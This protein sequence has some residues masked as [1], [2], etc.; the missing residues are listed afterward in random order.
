MAQQ[1]S[2]FILWFFVAGAVA[3]TA[4]YTFGAVVGDKITWR[5]NSPLQDVL[6]ILTW[7]LWL[8][9]IFLFDAEHLSQ[10]IPALIISG[11]FNGGWYALIGLL[12]WK[13]RERV[14]R[15]EKQES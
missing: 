8:T 7:I 11:P 13:I 3:P 12:V 14:V 1:R 5:P 10:I 6:W 2:R 9:W 4:L 15:P